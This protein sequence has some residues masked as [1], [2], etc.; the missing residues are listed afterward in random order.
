MHSC[1]LSMHSCAQSTLV[2]HIALD[3]LCAS[4]LP[5]SARLEPAC[6]PPV[7]PEYVHADV[8]CISMCV[9]EDSAQT[10]IRSRSNSEKASIESKRYNVSNKV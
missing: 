8:I 9:S 4:A 5:A 7:H 1:A 10:Y 2:V 3:E 6:R